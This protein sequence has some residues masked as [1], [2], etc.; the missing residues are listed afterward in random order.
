MNSIENNRNYHV[1]K[2]RY[3][4]C[5]E[6]IPVES[7]NSST[8]PSNGMSY[9]QKEG[10][11]LSYDITAVDVTCPYCFR[12]NQF[13][14]KD[15]IRPISRHE[16]EVLNSAVKSKMSLMRVTKILLSNEQVDRT[17]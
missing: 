10:A 5:N 6:I 16:Y 3:P 15:R 13:Q 7:F 4:G 17:E 8:I 14:I 9:L 11:G 1:F 12:T 2:C